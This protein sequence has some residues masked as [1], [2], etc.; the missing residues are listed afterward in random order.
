M[1]G[2][3]AGLTILEI[4]GGVATRYCGRLFATHGAT[5]L[6]VGEPSAD[7][8]GYGSRAST[9]YAAWLDHG[10]RRAEDIAAALA[11]QPVDL[12]SAGQTAASVERVDAALSGASNIV[13][14]RPAPIV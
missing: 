9:A 7:G 11:R 5:V 6:Q 14:L 3:L 12:V 1:S 4:P 2:P 13:R 10:K 8:V